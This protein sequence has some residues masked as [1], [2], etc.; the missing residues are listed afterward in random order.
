MTAPLGQ[1]VTLTWSIVPDGTFMPNVVGGQNRTSDLIGDFDLLIGTAGSQLTDRPWFS[2]IQDSFDRWSELSGVRFIY[3]PNDDG[4]TLGSIAGAL[5]VR[6]DIRLAGATIDGNGGAYGQAGFIPNADITLDTSDTLRFGASDDNY[7]ELRHTLMHEIG[8]SLGLGHNESF[9]TFVL[10]SPF[11]SDQFDGPQF[12]DIRGVQALYGD[13]FEAAGPSGNNTPATATPLG[14]LTPGSSLEVGLDA[15]T[16]AGQIVPSQTDFVSVANLL[17]RDYFSFTT[18][19]PLSVDI[20][21]MPVGPA[22]SERVSPNQTYT[23]VFTSRM[24]NL[25]VE[26]YDMTSGI[27][28]LIASSN[29]GGLGVAESILDLAL[30]TAGDFQVRVAGD[31]NQVQF[32]HLTLDAESLLPGDFNADGFVDAADYTVWRDNL[33]SMV[34]LPNAPQS[35]E[36]VDAEDYET[37]R[38]AFGTRL[39][40]AAAGSLT[41]VPEPVTLQI[42]WSVA[43]CVAARCI[44]ASRWRSR[45]ISPPENNIC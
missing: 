8:H 15:P 26:V 32:Y 21:L 39:P 5:G 38:A 17:D 19:Q 43:A 30:P 10:M 28:F 44:A 27:P 34:L 33:G 7:F 22:Y 3:E 36:V 24:N 9:N 45:P 29:A 18:D 4:A 40:V 25:G 2:V 42:L 16:G 41:A 12:D 14:A 13:K 37:W 1:P 6:G 23:P 11:A 35:P 31:S 20:V